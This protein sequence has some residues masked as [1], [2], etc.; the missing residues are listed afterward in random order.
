L[1]EAEFVLRVPTLVD[2]NP[3]DQN[4]SAETLHYAKVAKVAAVSEL[5]AVAD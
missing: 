4:P 3:V 2:Q 1:D 5:F